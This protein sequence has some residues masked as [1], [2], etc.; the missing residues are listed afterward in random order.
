MTTETLVSSITAQ[1]PFE[2]TAEQQEALQ[3]LARFLLSKNSHEVFL[4][5]GYAGTGK[6]SLISALI[7]YLDELQLDSLLMAPTGRAAKVL[8]SYSG[9]PA[10]TIH[11]TIYRKAVVSPEN[12][13]FAL[14]YNKHRNAVFIVDEASMIANESTENTSFG[15]GHLLED[16]LEFTFV[17]D[18][19]K[20]ILMGD[21]AQLPPV[22]L[23]LSPALD[24]SALRRLGMDTVE[25]ELKQVLRQ[26]SESGILAN[27]TA[28]RD[29]IRTEKDA[30][31]LQADER[32]MTGFKLFPQLKVNTADV[33]RLT[34]EEFSDSLSASF[35]K[36]GVEESKVICVSNKRAVLF[37]KGIRSTVLYR[38]DELNAG[39][40]LL[41]AKN[42]YLW[43]ENYPEIPFIANGDL[44]E[45]VRM[46]KTYEMYGF[47]F[48]DVE[49]RFPDYDWEVEVRVL[50]D[51]LH[52]ESPSLEPS[53]QEQLYQDVAL[54]YAPSCSSKAALYRALRKDP[55]LNALQIKYGYAFTCH[56]AQGGQWK[57]VYIDQGYVTE[58][59]MGLDYYRW[60]YTALTRATERVYLVNF[61][62]EF[63]TQ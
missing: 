45:V 9:H 23:T 18:N 51:A 10:Y 60:L 58:E 4:L 24:A 7:R 47:R 40:C 5:K 14:N 20:L 42:N 28:L 35:G 52:A 30:I 63:I 16:L 15:S 21:T 34:G 38:E 36:V 57:H 61:R 39:D 1:F 11:K 25:I 54:E 49:V 53:R 31:A 43:S 48:A 6:T 33:I 41:V 17:G 2:P 32:R 3:L 44:V 12:G 56:K 22:G 50:L 13:G 27:A 19:C 59:R 46:R 29:T 62:D 26:A 8:A 55:F 37:N